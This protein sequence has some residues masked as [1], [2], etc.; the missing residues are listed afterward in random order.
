MIKKSVRFIQNLQ[1]EHEKVRRRWLWILSSGAM[2]GIITIWVVYFNF[3]LPQAQEPSTQKAQLSSVQ[4][5]KNGF[6]VTVK[7]IK[8][9]AEKIIDLWK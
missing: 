5:L 4:V 2:L 6:V 1:S 7:Q 3:S 8:E 9:N